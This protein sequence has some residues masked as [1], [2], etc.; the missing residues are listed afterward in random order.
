MAQQPTTSKPGIRIYMI[1]MNLILLCLLFPTISIF[2]F[3]EIS[4]FRDTQ[5]NRTI[6]IM[7]KALETQAISMT[8]TLSLSAEQAMAGYD[9]TFLNDMMA[10]IV[11]NDPEI[12]Y[13]MVMS[14]TGQIIAHNQA[15]MIG[16]TLDDSLSSKVMTTI[17]PALITKQSPQDLP[18]KF[19]TIKGEISQ[20]GQTI[21][22]MEIITPIYNGVQALGVMR[23]GFSLSTLD[24][25]IDRVKHDWSNKMA[26]LK[27]FF[28]AI[29][30]I[31]FA[32]GLLVALF[33]SRFFIHSTTLLSQGAQL[34]A[35]GD[36]EHK[37]PAELMFCREFSQFANGFNTM[38]SRLQHSLHELDESN[39]SLEFKVQERTKDL[40]EAQSVLLQQAHEAGM[41]EM[42]VGVLHNIGN[43]ITPA[44]VDAVLLIRRLQESPLHTGLQEAIQE[45]V[46]ALSQPEKL[47]ITNRERLSEIAN[48]IP[49]TL[50]EEYSYAIAELRKICTKHEHIEGIINLQMRYAKLIGSHEEI[51]LNIV[52]K[53][54]LKMLNESITQREIIVEQ[55]L[56]EIQ[57]IKI[58]QAKMIQI[59][60]NLIKNG[61]EAMDIAELPERRL[62]ISTYME[63]MEPRQVVLTIK[64][65]GCGFTAEEK[66]KMFQF[67]Y[68]TKESGSGFGLHSCANFMKA[69]NGSLSA[70]SQGTGKGAQF[71]IKFPPHEA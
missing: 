43:A 18:K 22:V 41:A 11:D 32:I 50:Y 27:I 9:Y 70:S 1:L 10:Q 30:A 5:L 61:Y 48:L 55:D 2:L 38:T 31:F 23:C 69:N 20:D 3:S 36:F 47:S 4:S 24:S 13:S 26:R 45:I 14:S 16:F 12:L 8:R 49:S 40:E 56:G 6:N 7:R 57:L 63:K 29:T 19:S 15:E 51:D 34:I 53:D 59:V 39:R 17:R 35:D 54:A 52:V 64:D 37:I 60:I 58:E 65:T 67:G 42:A 25:E 66:E 71:M 46:S 62:L 28:L 21:P 68:T 44:K 33:F